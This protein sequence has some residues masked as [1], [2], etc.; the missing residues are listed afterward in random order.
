VLLLHFSPLSQEELE[1]GELPRIRYLKEFVDSGFSVKFFR[2]ER[3]RQR[4]V[5]DGELRTSSSSS[6]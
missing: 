4:M 3:E 1:R 5:R 2:E 6:L